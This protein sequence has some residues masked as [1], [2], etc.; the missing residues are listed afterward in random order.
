MRVSAR[1]DPIGV[2]DSGVGGL[3]I[4]KEIISLLP[5]E[6]VVYLGDT[7]RIPY[8]S[9]P[10]STIVQYSLENAR[11]LIAQNIKKIGKEKEVPIV[12]NKPLARSLYDS[13]EI[14]QIIPEELFQAVAEVLA[15]I[16][17]LNE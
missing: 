1:S 11:F 2:F 7:A 6:N 8:G 12:E 10:K 15:Y 9:K 13:V 17:S 16:Y 4:L 5:G 3:T 14:G